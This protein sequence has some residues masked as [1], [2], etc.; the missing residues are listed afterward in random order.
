MPNFRRNYVPGGT[1]FFTL[2]THGRRPIL[3]TPLARRCLREALVAE[4]GRAPFEQV[5]VVLLPDHL[6]AVWTLH[7]GD[8]DFPLRWQRIKERF[9][10]RY[11]TGGGAE[12][13]ITR[14]RSLRRER[15]VWQPRF[16]EH[17]VRDEDD[18]ERCLGYVH[19]NPVKHGLASTPGEYP[20]STFRKFVARE[21]YSP[22]WG[23]GRVPTVEVAGAEWD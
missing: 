2:V 18:F 21:W 6:H 12:G 17:T 16:W 14:N 20:W 3:T 7:E 9:T 11:L 22:E 1:Y 10:R 5:A 13:E 8:A 19:Y 23:T 4:R 15:G